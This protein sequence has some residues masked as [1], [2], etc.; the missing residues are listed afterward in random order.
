[1]LSS[2]DHLW[3]QLTA[4]QLPD[5]PIYPASRA[6]EPKQTDEALDHLY[7]PRSKGKTKVSDFTKRL[8]DAEEQQRADDAW[9][10]D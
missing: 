1:M 10:K 8:R 3:T 4:G 5:S 6:P 9:K 2:S 7:P